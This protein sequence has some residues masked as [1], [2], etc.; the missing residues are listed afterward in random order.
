M[1]HSWKMKA[2][3]VVAQHPRLAAVI[4]FV[5]KRVIMIGVMAA[6]L[7]YVAYQNHLDYER[8]KD[9]DTMHHDSVIPISRTPQSNGGENL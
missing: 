5:A 9:F 8:T 2:S 6:A 4:V 1:P 7:Y 3:T